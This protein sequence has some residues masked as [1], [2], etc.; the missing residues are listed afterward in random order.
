MP[1]DYIHTRVT[2]GCWSSFRDQIATQAFDALNPGGWFESQEFDGTIECD[3][4][5][6]R[7]DSALA[8]WSRDLCAASEAI[9]RP[10]V[11]AAGV[12][13]AY[14]EVG[15]VDVH[16]KV[17]KIPTNGWAKDARL[18]ELGRAWERN[19]TQGLSGFSTYLFHKVFDRSPAEIEVR[20]PL[21]AQRPLL[22][23]YT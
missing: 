7:P 6:L 21:S 4:G 13:A 12:R 20:L 11:M 3:D 17:F 18:K 14:E 9:D 1:F 23:A 10:I 8:R 15:F 2:A 22:L 5:T 16:Q 19:M